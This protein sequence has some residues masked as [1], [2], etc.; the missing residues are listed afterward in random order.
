MHLK[1]HRS[2]LLLIFALTKNNNHGCCHGQLQYFDVYIFANGR[3]SE[4]S[5]TKD[6]A[7]FLSV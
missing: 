1:N 5:S 3:I 2:I 4:V 6:N 7:K